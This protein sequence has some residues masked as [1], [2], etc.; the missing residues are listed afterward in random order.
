MIFGAVALLVRS[1]AP[2][3]L[4]AALCLMAL[5]SGL[6]LLLGLFTPVGVI[7]AL[8]CCAATVWFLI[9][10]PASEIL[11]IRPPALLVAIVSLSLGLIGPGAF[12]IDSRLFGRR[13]IVIPKR[14]APRK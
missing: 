14:T 9:P 10:I 11:E 7:L 13:E 2:T 8:L 5:A 1:G 3:L 12:S 6:S 4:S